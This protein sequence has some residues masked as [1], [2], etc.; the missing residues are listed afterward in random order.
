MRVSLALTIATQLIVNKLLGDEEDEGAHGH[1]VHASLTSEEYNELHKS[2]HAISADT[3][4]LFIQSGEKVW[5]PTSVFGLE[6]VVVPKLMMHLKMDQV[7]TGYDVGPNR[8]EGIL[9]RMMDP[10]QPTSVRAFG[11][12][13]L[14][15]AASTLGCTLSD[16]TQAADECPC[17]CSMSPEPCLLSNVPC[18]LPCNCLLLGFPLILF[19][20][21]PLTL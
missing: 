6:A 11:A 8:L 2:S 21:H 18:P 20:F 17:L 12:W 4:D 16:A 15:W 7:A 13:Q 14:A 5:S 1:D 19:S 3:P 9:Y 10:T